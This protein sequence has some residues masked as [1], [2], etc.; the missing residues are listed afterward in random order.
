MAHFRKLIEP[1]NWQIDED[2]SGLTI[3]LEA[4]SPDYPLGGIGQI[5]SFLWLAKS[6]RNITSSNGLSCSYD[7]MNCFDGF[8][9]FVAERPPSE[10]LQL[11]P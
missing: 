1:V 4:Q 2:V 3:R 9:G 8:Q 10:G 6:C 7:A 5:M 11:L